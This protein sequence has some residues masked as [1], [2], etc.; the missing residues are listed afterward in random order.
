MARSGLMGLCLSAASCQQMLGLCLPT[1][2]AH[3]PPPVLAACSEPAGAGPC[4]QPG[5]TH[6]RPCL[7]RAVSPLV[8]APGDSLDS[9]QNV[10]LKPLK[11]KEGRF[12][13]ILAALRGQLYLEPAGYLPTQVRSCWAAASTAGARGVCWQE[14]P[15][16]GLAP[17][18][19]VSLLVLW[20]RLHQPVL[21]LSPPP[22]PRGPPRCHRLLSLWGRLPLQHDTLQL[23]TNVLAMKA[24]RGYITCL[25]RPEVGFGAGVWGRRGGG[26]GYEGAA[27]LQHL[28]APARCG[29]SP[30]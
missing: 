28:P 5:L 13:P 11:P 30:L 25:P 27:R 7:L 2:W 18:G 24:Q 3:A 12:L 9:Q 22:P 4:R 10:R 17:S 1:A 20:G 6:H 8:L 26:A 21:D 23:D 19:A 29:G 14:H 15:C 16:M